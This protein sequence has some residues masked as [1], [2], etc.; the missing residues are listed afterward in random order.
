MEI[1]AEVWNAYSEEAIEN[2]V[3]RWVSPQ[4][5]IDHLLKTVRMKEVE[6]AYGPQEDSYAIDREKVYEI[7]KSF[8]HPDWQDEGIDALSGPKG[9][10]RK[11][12]YLRFCVEGGDNE[13]EAVSLLKAAGYFC[14]DN[15]EVAHAAFEKSKEHVWKTALSDGC[16]DPR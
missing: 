6:I 15:D 12:R 7:V 10:D 3:R 13:R 8:L 2:E 16:R 5:A 11:Y 4:E 9:P 14:R 1:P